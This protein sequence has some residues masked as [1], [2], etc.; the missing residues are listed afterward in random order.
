MELKELKDDSKRRLFF[1]NCASSL[2]FYCNLSWLRFQVAGSCENLYLDLLSQME[3][4]F[5]V[6]QSQT[7]VYCQMPLH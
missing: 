2:S 3:I 7:I 1:L 6:K 4:I 5:L